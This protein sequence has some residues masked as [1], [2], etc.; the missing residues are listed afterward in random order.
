MAKL[1]AKFGKHYSSFIGHHGNNFHGLQWLE[2]CT[3]SR[4]IRLTH[5]FCQCLSHVHEIVELHQ[6]LFGHV[7]ERLVNSYLVDATR[8]NQLHHGFESITLHVLLTIRECSEDVSHAVGCASAL[9]DCLKETNSA[10]RQILPNVPRSIWLLLKVAF[11]G[12]ANGHRIQ[13]ERV[14]P[15][16]GVQLV[17]DHSFVA[18]LSQSVCN[19]FLLPHWKEYVMLNTNDQRWHH[20]AFEALQ[21]ARI[22]VLV[23]FL[24]G[25]TIHRLGDP[26]E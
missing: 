6:R 4:Q 14:V 17:V 26:Q 23:Q 1:G 11:N 18:C 2:S 5:C 7:L 24:E 10:T 16:D 3:A 20:S 22:S 13:Q 25:E 9:A 19:L 12:R 21:Q 8:P 15:V